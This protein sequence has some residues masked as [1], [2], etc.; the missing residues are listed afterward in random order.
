MWSIIA[1]KATLGNKI[2]F[3]LL[4]AVLVTAIHS[5][6]MAG[7]EDEH[8]MTYVWVATATFVSAFVFAALAVPPI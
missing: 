4:I 7:K 5:M 2:S 8:Q 3:V 1:E 6:Y